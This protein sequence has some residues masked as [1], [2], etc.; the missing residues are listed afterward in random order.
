MSSELISRRA[1]LA[2]GAAALG[3]SAAAGSGTA[4]AA[5]AAAALPTPTS[6]TAGEPQVDRAFLRLAEGLVHYRHAGAP[7]RSRGVPLPL[8]LAHAGPGSSRAFEPL[9]PAFGRRRFAFAPDMLGNGDSAAPASEDV[10][11]AYYVDAAVR[12]LD[13]LGLDAVD[14]YGS[15]TGAQIGVELAIAQPRRVRRLV[16]DGIPLFAPQFRQ[17]LLANYAPKQAPDEFG[18]HLSWAWHFV[19]DQQLYWPYFDRSAGNRL[20]NAVPPPAQLQA[21]VTD[22]LKALGT[23]HIAYRAAFRQDTAALLPQLRCPV[24]ITASER[25]PLSLYLDDAA[26]LIPGAIKRRWSRETTLADRIAAVE[27]FLAG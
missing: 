12:I 10:A 5:A 23:Y 26:A 6:A 8:Y 1:T 27:G 13:A 4:A 9:L 2:F 18:G 7:P 17:Q 15:H 20:A 24:L 19:R 25:D 11:I 22:V 14:F 3:G 21:S 16:L